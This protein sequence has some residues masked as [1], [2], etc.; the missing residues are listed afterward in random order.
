MKRKDYFRSSKVGDKVGK[1]Q[2]IAVME[3]SST[4]STSQ[5]PNTNNPPKTETPKPQAVTTFTRRLL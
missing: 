3:V 1:G 4:A 2:L 5:A